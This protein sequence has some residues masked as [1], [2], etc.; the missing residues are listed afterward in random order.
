M[1]A[2]ERADSAVLHLSSL[3][4]D[5]RG[6]LL[7]S[8]SH[9][10]STQS[11]P[12]DNLSDHLQQ[13]PAA[14]KNKG[15]Q[16]DESDAPRP[17]TKKP[18]RG[19]PKGAKDRTPGSRQNRSNAAYQLWESRRQRGEALPPARERKA[20]AARLQAQ[21]S[22]IAANQQASRE[23]HLARARRKQAAGAGAG[24]GAGSS[25]AMPPGGVDN[26]RLHPRGLHG[27]GGPGS[28]F[29]P[30]AGAGTTSVAD[31]LLHTTRTEATPAEAAQPIFAGAG[32]P[33]PMFGGSGS[34]FRPLAESKHKQRAE[35][36]RSPTS[37]ILALPAPDPSAAGPSR[38]QQG[39]EPSGVGRGRRSR[40][41]DKDPSKSNVNR[42]AAALAREAKRIAAG[43]S[44]GGKDPEAT[45]AKIRAAK[46]ERDAR[47]KAEF[48]GS[49]AFKNRE[50]T[51]ANRRAGAQRRMRHD[52]LI[53][54]SST[55]NGQPQ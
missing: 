49:Y 37:A 40:G 36:T 31:T 2:T 24:T 48:I 47:K 25:T 7:G 1:P 29:S 42:R 8:T 9:A 32:Q 10:Q 39:A 35:P 4:H 54:E 20:A 46:L 33:R 34:A 28:A 55:V 3:V 44:W 22:L 21:Q 19:R 13:S 30:Y 18:G 27:M 51:R 6:P 41:K 15:K 45:R 50:L 14:P 23:A 52:S 53:L 16:V 43:I 38:P 17:S 11:A 5:H 12:Q 26:R